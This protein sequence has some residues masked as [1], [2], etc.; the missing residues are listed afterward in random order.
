[1]S[2]FQG[3][4][5]Q[6]IATAVQETK[7]VVYNES[8]SKRWEDE[9]LT[10]ENVAPLLQSGAVTLRLEA[11]SQE[12]GFLAQ[13]YPL[14]K[15]PT[16][17]VIKN[18][19]LKEYIVSGVAKEDF[20]RRIT[21][22]LKLATLPAQPAATAVSHAPSE[23]H[24]QPNPADSSST[25][26]GRATP[27]SSTENQQAQVQAMLTERAARLV[28]QKKK[29]EEEA[30][31]RRIEKGKAKAVNPDAQSKHADTLKRKQREAREERQRILKAI[32]DD[33][34]ARREAQERREAERRAA[35][36]ADGGAEPQV[37]ESTF[38][39]AS[40]LYPKSG[41]IT[42]HC[43]LQVRLLNGSTIRSKFLSKDT[44]KDV[45]QW[46][47]QT[48]NG[49]VGGSG[50]GYTFKI[51]LTPLPNRTVDVTE[52]GK[53][54]QELDLTPS[55]TLIL[56]PVTKAVEAYASGSR[57]ILFAPIIFLLAIFNGFM[58]GV[59]MFFSTLFSTAGP[60]SARPSQPTGA[61]QT[62]RGATTGRDGRHDQQFYNG[63]STNF[64]PRP[65]DED[66]E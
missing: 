13:L 22:V 16:V 32:E 11:G 4:L 24:S 51:L 64:E 43:A 21:Q 42:E 1:M 63:N 18:S 50:K 35:A 28:A 8:E 14:P 3:T 5:Q 53:T 34:I 57:S 49:D 46:V 45:R 61:D 17:V 27:P 59:V 7:S 39:P 37:A 54:L 36:A 29:D 65:E 19:E 31:K 38:A 9:Y 6:G 12:E 60:P 25:S 55:A 52:E 20:I 23:A 10:D 41:R 40:P 33:K 44:L 15:K 58:R 62:G 30:R 47:E 66:E 2:F 48:T 26:S 56:I